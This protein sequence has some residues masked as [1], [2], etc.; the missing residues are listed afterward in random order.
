MIRIVRVV[1]MIHGDDIG[2]HR[3]FLIVVIVGHDAHELRALDQKRSV[4]D[5]GQPNLVGVK[6]GKPQRRGSDRG[7]VRGDKAGAAFPH[8]RRRRQCLRR[9]RCGRDANRRAHKR[10]RNALCDAD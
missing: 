4:A 5:E 9:L 10:G 8:F 7:T 6:L 1:R 2:Q 3:R